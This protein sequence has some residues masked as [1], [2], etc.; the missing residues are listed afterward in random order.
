MITKKTAGLL[1]ALF[2]FLGSC[3]QPEEPY[4]EERDFFI[5]DEENL[6]PLRKNQRPQVILIPSKNINQV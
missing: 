4:Q 2:T 1:L 5:S 3:K 6:L